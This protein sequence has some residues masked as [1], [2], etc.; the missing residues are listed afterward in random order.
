MKAL[1][2]TNILI[3]YLNGINAARDEIDRYE[4]P[5]ISAISWMEVM[6]GVTEEEQPSIRSFLSRFTQI[7]NDS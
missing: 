7:A 3:D 2:D 4:T 5:L 1:M 6:V